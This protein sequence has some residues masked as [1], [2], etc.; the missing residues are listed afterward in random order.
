VDA[1][2]PAP[3]PPDVPESGD[4]MVLFRRG[5]ALSSVSEAEDRLAGAFL[6][7]GEGR[8]TGVSFPD[9]ARAGDTSL[10]RT[11]LDDTRVAAGGRSSPDV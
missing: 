7:L 5:A 3:S 4:G 2:R 1:F 6:F 11:I 9:A 8:S 10:G